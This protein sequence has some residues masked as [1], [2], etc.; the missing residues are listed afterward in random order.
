MSI[1]PIDSHYRVVNFGPDEFESVPESPQWWPIRKV[2]LAPG[3]QVMIHGDGT[4]LIGLV[5]KDK[6]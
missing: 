4:L 1:A 2:L 3:M 6:T 5:S